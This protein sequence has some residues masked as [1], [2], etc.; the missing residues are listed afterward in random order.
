MQNQ[1]HWNVLKTR[2]RAE[3]QVAS[4]LTELG[5]THYLPLQKQ[6]RKWHDRLKWVEIPLFSTYIFVKTNSEPESKQVLRVNGVVQYLRFGTETAKLSEQEIER[7]KRLCA[8]DQEIEI[9]QTTFE[10]GEE[11]EVMEGFFSGFVGILIAQEQKNKL[12]ISFPT[13]QCYA[14]IE[15]DKSICRKFVL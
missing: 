4:R 13:L 14:S 6:Q 12:R 11:V 15:I 5:I 2:S 3:K 7:I 1:S 10:I 9:R 8:S